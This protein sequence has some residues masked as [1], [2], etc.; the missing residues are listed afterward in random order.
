MN[1][2]VLQRSSEVPLLDFE[3]GRYTW[4]VC[5]SL[6][7]LDIP[8]PKKFGIERQT[9]DCGSTSFALISGLCKGL[10]AADCPDVYLGLCGGCNGASSLDHLSTAVRQVYLKQYCFLQRLCSAAMNVVFPP[11]PYPWCRIWWPSYRQSSSTMYKQCIWAGH[12]L[13]FG[14][15]NTNSYLASLSGVGQ[16]A[17]DLSE[18]CCRH[19]KHRRECT[20]A[21]SGMLRDSNAPKSAKE[22]SGNVIA[23][24]QLEEMFPK[25]PLGQVMKI[26]PHTAPAHL[27]DML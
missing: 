1:F 21:S 14:L 17:L 3:Q 24:D 18:H 8:D 16:F 10:F 2:L 7:Y 15:L 19:L 9:F 5:H 12:P 20:Q 6:D 13:W 22:D 27:Q 11:L 4:P 25:G 26:L 23:M